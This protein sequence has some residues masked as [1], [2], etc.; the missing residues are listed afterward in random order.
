MQKVFSRLGA[1]GTGTNAFLGVSFLILAV[2][3]TLVAAGEITAARA[4]EATGR[5]DHLLVQP[6]G[7][8][9]WL[10]GRLLVAAAAVAAGGVIAGV[11]SWIATTTQN[12]GVGLTNVLGAG[13]N[14][15]PPAVCVLGVG[16]L[17]FGVWPRAASIVVH[18]L[19]G[20]SLVIEVIGGVGALSHWVLD[21]SVFHQV[22]SA[23]AVA[24]NWGTNAVL[25]ALGV[26]GGAIGCATFCRRDL[27]GA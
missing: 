24:P 6:V 1:S 2:L 3:V 8:S 27:H 12:A 13:L 26:A 4:E 17:A 11:F 10:G 15:V 7:R 14:I 20:W 21:T 22:A 18:G 19:L 23:P 5:L 9:A 16:A 25:L